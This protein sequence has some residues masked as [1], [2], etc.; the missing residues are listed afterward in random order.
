MDENIHTDMNATIPNQDSP[1]PRVLQVRDERRF[2]II[3]GK[4][5][6]KILT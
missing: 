3:H 5:I 1:E 2:D 6:T 4:L